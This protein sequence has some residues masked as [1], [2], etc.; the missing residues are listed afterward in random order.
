MAKQSV[1]KT[2]AQK[3]RGR[4]I[5]LIHVA[6]N[7]LGLDD[8]TY[9]AMLT[10]TTGKTSSKDCTLPQ[11]RSVLDTLKTKGFTVTPNPSKSSAPNLGEKPQVDEV[12]QPMLGKIEALLL[13]GGYTWSYANGIAKNM[14][15]KEKINLCGG[16]E[17]HQ[18]IVALE[19]NSKRN[20]TKV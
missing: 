16:Q 7:E 10:N 20:A 12:L 19:Y 3:E 14:F 8:D 9:R 17:M 13:D 6:K 4:L 15:N 1:P 2:K 11:L 5:T 18:I